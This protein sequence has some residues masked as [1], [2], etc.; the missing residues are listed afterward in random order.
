MSYVCVQ[1]LFISPFHSVICGVGWKTHK[2][3]PVNNKHTSFFFG[4]FQNVCV[5]SSR[6]VG[7]GLPTLVYFLQSRAVG[8]Q[9]TCTNI[10]AHLRICIIIHSRKSVEYINTSCQIGVL[11]RLRMKQVLVF[12]FCYW[13]GFARCEIQHLSLEIVNISSLLQEAAEM[14]Q[15]SCGSTTPVVVNKGYQVI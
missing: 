2:P 8:Q 11:I 13:I 9:T 15:F 7:C 10:S 3:R 5:D 4:S 1:Y 6:V 12:L 14:R